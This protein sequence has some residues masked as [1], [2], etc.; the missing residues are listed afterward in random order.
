MDNA[1]VT[2]D[3]VALLRERFGY[4]TFRPGQEALIR[5]VLSGQDALGVLPTGGGKSVCYQIPAMMIGGLTLVVTPLVSLMQDQVVRA[6]GAGLNAHCLTA[7][8]TRRERSMV[9]GSLRTGRV[10]LLF[11]SPERLL[12]ASF[13]RAIARLPIGLIA[14]DEAHCI[15]EW[16]HDF[17]P[18]YRMIGTFR[19][20]QP[21]P[22]LA[23]T[24]SA[25]PAVRRDITASLGLRRP[26]V[27]LHSFDRP[28][29][30]WAIKMARPGRDRLQ[31]LVEIAFRTPGTGIV[32]APTRTSVEAVRRRLSRAGIAAEAYHAGL[33]GPLRSAVQARFM[34]G[35]SRVVV[36]TNAFGMGID[37]PDVRYVLHLQLPTTLEAYYQ[38]AGRAGR[39]GERS[40]CVAFHAVS[41]RRLG[42]RFINRTHPHEAIVRMVHW[43]LGHLAGRGGWLACDDPRLR[44]LMGPEVNAWQSGEGAP[45]LSTL[46]RIDAICQEGTGLARRVSPKS[47][48][49]LLERPNW[50]HLRDLRRSALDRL[51]AVQR[52]A[53]TPGCRRN[54]LLRYFGESVAVGCGRCDGCGWDSGTRYL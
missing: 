48:I 53:I 2:A 13:R 9:I 37:K 20:G 26:K 39:D 47:G 41:D 30:W 21:A 33:P 52:L 19:D 44:R 50:R 45:F 27:V 6:C 15:S 38:E 5:S 4:P 23:L 14:V 10:D 11:V 34:S 43:R 29:L 42:L 28:N 7:A 25:T 49:R 32:Y 31:R 1:P 8:Q 46:E 3:P 40:M 36:A 24:A 51:G 54:G 22:V 12:A 17:R 35:T 18:A 16:G